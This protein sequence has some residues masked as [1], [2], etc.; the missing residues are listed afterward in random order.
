MPLKL[1]EGIQHFRNHVYQRDFFEKLSQGQAPDVLLITCS[2]SRIVPG[3]LTQS[4][5]GVL[6][7]IRNAGNI[8]ASG[9]SWAGI[10]YAIEKLNIRDLIVCGHSHCG[11]MQGLLT[12]KLSETLPHTAEWLVHSQVLLKNFEKRH[13]GEAQNSALALP[14]ITQEN[15][16]LQMEYLKTHPSVNHRLQKGEL[17]IHGWYYV[18]EKGEVDIYDETQNQ[19]VSFES[20][21][22]KVA[23]EI[24]SDVLE[25]VVKQYVTSLDAKQR[26]E[27]LT[28]FML[29]RSLKSSWP[30]MIAPVRQAMTEKVG[31]LYQTKSGELSERFEALLEE[32]K[33]VSFESYKRLSRSIQAQLIGSKNSHRLFA[34]PPTSAALE[35]RSF[36]SRL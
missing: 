35:P 29:T 32:G 5:A 28:D 17:R 18:L 26:H 16:V 15:V 4:D 24:L 8:V 23:K 12:P 10:E 7:V 19:F 1:L 36:I 11:A 3:Q 30:M 13:P 21:V 34:S 2:D 27:F 25:G 20:Y 31:R 14:L 22:D 33:Q 9:S 6:F